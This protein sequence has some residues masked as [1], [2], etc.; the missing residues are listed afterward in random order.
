LNDT[1]FEQHHVYR[2]E[3]QP[4]AEGHLSWWIDDEFIMSIG[5]QSMQELTGA[6]I[7]EEPMY[8]IL[9]VAL[10]HLWGMPEPCDS[11]HCSACW[12]CYDC[13]NPGTRITTSNCCYVSA[14]SL[15]PT[16]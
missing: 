9:N 6:K 8:L 3:W 13:T 1:H 12:I 2:L 14:V 15:K 4:G 5:G 10:S 11:E 7:P 16:I